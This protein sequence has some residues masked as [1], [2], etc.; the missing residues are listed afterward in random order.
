MTAQVVTLGYDDTGSVRTKIWRAQVVADGSGN[1]S[2]DYTEAGF[3]AAPIVVAS[4]QNNTGT[5]V[6]QAWAHVQSAS[7]TAATGTAIRGANL[8]ALGATVRTA[9]GV[10]VNVVAVGT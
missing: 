8:A 10:S 4:G 5:L 1:W 7:A 6:D 9:P 3:S 2:V